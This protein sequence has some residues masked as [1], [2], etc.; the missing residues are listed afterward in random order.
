MLDPS[1]HEL[2]GAHGIATAVPVGQKY[3]AGQGCNGL[4]VLAFEHRNP[5]VHG[6]Q[7]AAFLFRGV[8]E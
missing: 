2:P 7:S 5:A 4:T 8:L 6:R 3:P 1:R